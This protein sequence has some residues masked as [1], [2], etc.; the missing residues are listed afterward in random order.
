LLKQINKCFV[1]GLMGVSL[2]GLSGSVFASEA[3]ARPEEQVVGAAIFLNERVAPSVD[4]TLLKQL[5]V[6]ENADLLPDAA[7]RHAAQSQP[8]TSLTNGFALS[9]QQQEAD[10]EHRRQEARRDQAR[11]NEKQSLRGA[12]C[13][14]PGVNYSECRA[15]VDSKIAAGPLNKVMGESADSSIRFNVFE[16]NCDQNGVCN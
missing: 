3:A 14:Q 15:G 6:A 16:W 13:D 2:S 7:A 9:L 11:Q 12:N 8:H 4:R 10:K 5:S 1:L